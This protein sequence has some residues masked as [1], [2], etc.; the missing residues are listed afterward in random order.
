M[1]YN[2]GSVVYLAHIG[3]D[4]TDCFCIVSASVVPASVAAT[5]LS[6]WGPHVL[7]H[8]VAVNIGFLLTI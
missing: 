3:V 8:C 1:C 4:F 7:F 5:E 2:I 6:S